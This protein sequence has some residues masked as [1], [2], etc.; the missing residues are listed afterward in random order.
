MM[1]TMIGILLFMMG[2]S[3]MAAELKSAEETLPLCEQSATL[4]SEGKVAKSFDILKPYWPH[5]D[6]AINALSDKIDSQMGLL[7]KRFGKV[8][9][10]EFVNSKKAGSSFLRHV[11][12]I[13]FE[14]TVLRYTCVFYKPKDAWIVNAINVDDHLPLLFD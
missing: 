10:A 11:F 4:L 14:K 12:I 13:K 5:T 9:N 1:K 6:T 7:S 8:L 3:A 2:S